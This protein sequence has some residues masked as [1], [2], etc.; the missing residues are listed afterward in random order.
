MKNISLYRILLSTSILWMGLHLG[1]SQK[2]EESRALEDIAANED[3]LAFMKTFDGRGALSDS[4]QPTSPQKSL[5]DFKYPDDI[6]LDL[7]LSEPE[8]TQP[9]FID[10]DHRGRLWVVQYNQYPYPKDLKVTSMDQHIRATFDK[11]PPPPGK[12]PRGADK[13]TFFEDTDGD[14]V[15]EKSTDAITGF[16]AIVWR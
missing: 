11:I 5:V 2:P 15:F 6:R 16:H 14:G 12:G 8:V 1:C 7:I 9:V 3:V 13:I 4:S 10:F